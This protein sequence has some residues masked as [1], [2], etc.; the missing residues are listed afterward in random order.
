[1]GAGAKAKFAALLASA[2]RKILLPLP[3]NFNRT[4]SRSKQREIYI[5]RTGW[6]RGTWVLEVL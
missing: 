5:A 4:A 6:L 2:E 1:M 3:E